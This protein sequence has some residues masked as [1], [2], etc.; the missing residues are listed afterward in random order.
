MKNLVVLTLMLAIMPVAFSQNTINLGNIIHNGFVKSQKK[1]PFVEFRMKLPFLYEFAV[2][3]GSVS[4]FVIEELL[5]SVYEPHVFV[6]CWTS[7]SLFSA[8]QEESMD[9]VFKIKNENFYERWLM[10]NV[11]AWNTDSLYSLGAPV[12]PH[13]E[14]MAGTYYAYRIIL[15]NGDTTVNSIEFYPSKREIPSSQKEGDSLWYRWIGEDIAWDDDEYDEDSLI[16]FS[17]ETIDIRSLINERIELEH[18]DFFKECRNR[19]AVLKK[20]PCNIHS[21]TIY[22]IEKHSSEKGSSEAICWSN[23]FAYTITGTI[24]HEFMV[25]PYRHLG[26]GLVGVVERWDKSVLQRVQEETS[27]SDENYNIFRLIIDEGAIIT[28][29]FELHKHFSTSDTDWNDEKEPLSNDYIEHYDC[30]K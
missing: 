4:V 11:Q 29:Y 8:R 24:D 3:N 26:K 21:D 22:V 6:S 25:Y 12:V 10:D 19:F 27:G 30:S 13:N 14:E 18:E 28:Y 5:Y 15:N 2:N 20:L 16:D 9:I 1:D 17:D 7:H 23:K